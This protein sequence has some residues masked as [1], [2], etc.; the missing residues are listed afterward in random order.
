MFTGWP[1]PSYRWFKEIY[2]NDTLVEQEVDPLKDARITISGGQLIVNNPDPVTDRG[3]YFCKAR[4]SF[5]TIRSRCL[6]YQKLQMLVY[7][8]L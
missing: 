3:K 7:R 6:A 5:G 1:T 4:N 2:K 8:H